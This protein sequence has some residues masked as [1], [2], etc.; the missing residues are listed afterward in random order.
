MRYAA[1]FALLLFV[2]SSYSLTAEF[3]I[4]PTANCSNATTGFPGKCYSELKSGEC[5]DINLW[6][7]SGFTILLP[8]LWIASASAFSDIKVAM[9]DQVKCQNYP[10]T[11]KSNVSIA[12]NGI[13]YTQLYKNKTISYKFLYNPKASL[14]THLGAIGLA[15]LVGGI[16][17][18]CLKFSHGKTYNSYTTL[19]GSPPVYEDRLVH[20][21]DFSRWEKVQVSAGTSP[22]VITHQNTYSCKG[23]IICFALLIVGY[24]LF[25]TISLFS[26][27]SF[28]ENVNS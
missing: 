3:C 12:Q 7:D 4:Y 10:A 14:L 9:F 2:S 16:I 28:N 8:S 1:F 20:Y 17:I 27:G 25:T 5:S 22:Q 11:I 23:C 15:F 24:I 6:S 19:S 18:C 13:C 21:K 26:Y